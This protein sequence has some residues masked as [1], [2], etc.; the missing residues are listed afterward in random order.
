MA[1]KGKQGGRAD[2]L[3]QEE[4]LQAIVIADSFNVR[5]GPVTDKKPRALLPLVNTAMIDYVLNFLEVQGVQQAFVFCCHHADQ[6]RV[7]LA[8]SRWSEDGLSPMSVKT[9]LADGCRSVGDALREIDSR[10]LTRSDFFLLSCDTIAN[11]NLKKMMAEHKSRREEIKSAVMTMNCMKMPAKSKHRCYEDNIILGMEPKRLQ[12]CYYEKLTLDRKIRI[13]K[14][15]QDNGKDVVIH[16]DLMD[17]QLYVCSPTVL[18]LF[19]DN[20]DYGSIEDF[21]HGILINEEILGHS[22]HVNIL[23]NEYCLRVT[24]PYMYDIISRDII[25]HRTHPVTPLHRIG[26]NPD[27]LNCHWPHVHLSKGHKISR[28]VKL[29]QCLVIGSGT[30][31]Q[32]DADITNCVIGRNCKIG[33]NVKLNGSYVWDNVTIE[34]GCIVNGSIVCSGVT[35]FERTE[36][37]PQTILSWN[38]KVGPDVKLEPNLRLKDAP[39][40]DPFADPDDVQIPDVTPEYGLKSKAFIFTGGLDDEDEDAQ[41]DI[42]TDWGETLLCG[43]EGT[44]DDDSGSLEPAPTLELVDDED[45][46]AQEE[47][48]EEEDDEYEQFYKEVVATLKRAAAEKVSSENVILE[49][50]SLKH[51]YNIA[52]AEVYQSV[53]RALLEIPFLGNPGVPEKQLVAATLR[54]VAGYKGLL[55]NYIK[56]RNEQLDCLHTIEEFVIEHEPALCILTP[57]VQYLYQEDLLAEEV[58]LEWYEAQID[59]DDEEEDEEEREQH[60]RVRNKIKA[61][62]TWLKE[63]DEESDD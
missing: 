48:T 21:V 44:V 18:H 38:V 47:E 33:K 3:K 8:N 22:V 63:A 16:E 57:V 7:H 46:Q 14:D 58:I 31:I 15:L 42:D 43:K 45:V 32:D 27:E 36:V 4:I 51:A 30:V 39:K 24:N 26:R 50:N 9:V 61:F 29:R 2:D 54:H 19:T 49:T 53:L 41:E 20:F 13:P 56:K 60:L 25:R 28:G 62:V 1:P 52:I 23:K 35:I 59:D 10:S 34:D 40:I 37:Q 55:S 12:I 11:V 17:C 5:F 6:I